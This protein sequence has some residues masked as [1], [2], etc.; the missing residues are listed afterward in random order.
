[1]ST[2]DTAE[3]GTTTAPAVM[4]VFDADGDEYA[5]LPGSLGGSVRSFRAAHGHRPDASGEISLSNDQATRAAAHLATGAPDERRQDTSHNG[6]PSTPAEPA[7]IE[8]YSN[9]R[10]AVVLTPKAPPE[11]PKQG[12]TGADPTRTATTRRPFLLRLFDKGM[13]EHPG[14]V[15]KA[16]HPAPVAATPRA[17]GDLASGFPHAGGATGTQAEGIGPVRNS[18]RTSPARWD[19]TLPA[20]PAQSV[21]RSSRSFRA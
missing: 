20:A 15:T 1:M 5:A 3:H 4:D 21:A 13:A 7:A 14:P 8:A 12:S 18:L 6:H 2:I 11:R 16:V 19:T 17:L 10:A 9:E